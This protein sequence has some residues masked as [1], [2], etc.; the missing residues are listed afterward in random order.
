MHSA[1]LSSMETLRRA[2]AFKFW[3]IKPA[4][5]FKPPKNLF[6]E[7]TLQIMLDNITKGDRKLLEVNDLIPVTDKKPNK[8]DDLR[9]SNESCLM[10]LVCGVSED[11]P[12]LITILASKPILLEEDNTE[13]ANRGNGVKKSLKLYGVSLINMM[14]NIRIWTGLHPDPEG[15][16]NLKLISRVLESNDEVTKDELILCFGINIL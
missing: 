7:V 3:E 2:Q 10:A 1:L 12:N 13:T 16:G 5:D 8:I 14:T 15:G 6:Y 11:R 9:C 4:K